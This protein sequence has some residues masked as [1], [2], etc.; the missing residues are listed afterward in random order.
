MKRMRIA[1]EG[2][3][4]HD[5]RLIAGHALEWPESVVVTAPPSPRSYYGPEVV[6]KATNIQREPG[7]WITADIEGAP[8][9]LFPEI[10]VTAP[11]GSGL[12]TSAGG[13]V[14]LGARLCAVHFGD[15]PVWDGLGPYE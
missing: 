8:P 1:R 10:R 3:V 14:L 6:G 9:K 7:G 12:K 15:S 5:G 11:L 13:D 2:V 4:T